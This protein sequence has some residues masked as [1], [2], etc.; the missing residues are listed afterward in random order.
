MR[1]ALPGRSKSD[2][3]SPSSVTPLDHQFRQLQPMPW[4]RALR[5]S[6]DMRSID[7]GNAQSGGY[8]R[9]GDVCKQRLNLLREGFR[10]QPI[11]EGGGV[12][13]GNLGGMASACVNFHIKCGWRFQIKSFVH[14]MHLF[15]SFDLV[16]VSPLQ[17]LEKFRGADLRIGP[18]P[19]ESVED[20]FR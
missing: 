14:L 15:G 6:M 2:C 4:M 5:A 8:G 17:S 1:S 19:R 16:L 11:R 20:R 9:L 18:L 3:G 13:R 12:P 10:V 7:P